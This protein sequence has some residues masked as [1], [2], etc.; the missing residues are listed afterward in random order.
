[1][2][3]EVAEL[4]IGPQGRVVIPAAMRRALG[5]E[6]GQTLV[7]HIEEGRLV[8]E[9]R[10]TVLRRVQARFADAV[11]RDVSVAEELI[12]E[13]RQEARREAEEA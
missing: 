9:P 4:R 3:D 8:L 1:M 2:A 6:P 13:R 12:S 7:G 5:L 11:P 10:D